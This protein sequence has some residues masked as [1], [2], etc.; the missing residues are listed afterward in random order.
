[1]ATNWKTYIYENGKRN[2]TRINADY[3]IKV[4]GIVDG[5]KVNHLLGVSGLVA[6][7]GDE[8][9]DKFICRA[10]ASGMDSTHCKLRRGIKVSFYNK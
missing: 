6:L 2:I 3:R 10:Y 9:T 5:I 4:Y 8:L 1:M 7:I